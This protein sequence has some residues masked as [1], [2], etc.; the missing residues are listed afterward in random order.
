MQCE[1]AFLSQNSWHPLYKLLIFPSDSLSPFSVVFSS[2]FASGRLYIV[3]IE[4][5]QDSIPLTRRAK[6][7]N[8]STKNT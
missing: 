3:G 4:N 8:V 2:I 7:V 5:E 6:S 1:L